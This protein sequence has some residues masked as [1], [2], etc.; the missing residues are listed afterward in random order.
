MLKIF[1]RSIFASTFDAVIGISLTFTHYKDLDDF[2]V[3]SSMLLILNDDDDGP[4][5]L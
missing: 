5:V 2:K 4:L 3:F 1:I